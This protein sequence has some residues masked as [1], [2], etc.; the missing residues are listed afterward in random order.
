ML[1]P[2]PD[3]HQQTESADLPTVGL[4]TPPNPEA[5]DQSFAVDPSR[6]DPSGGEPQS[7][8]RIGFLVVDRIKG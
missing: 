5:A 1:K 2:E 3:W 7:S 8:K 4:S 6:P